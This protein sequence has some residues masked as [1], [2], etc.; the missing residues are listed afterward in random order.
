MPSDAQ[1]KAREAKEAHERATTC[2]FGRHVDN[3][4]LRP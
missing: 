2:R 1:R 4:A 3:L